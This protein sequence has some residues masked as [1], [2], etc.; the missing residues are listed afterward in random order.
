MNTSL[1]GGIIEISPDG[2]P[3]SPNLILAYRSGEKQGVI[4]NTQSF[5][6]ANHLMSASEISFDVHK[7]SGDTLCI[8]WD[9]IKDFKFVFVPHLG[10]ASFNPWYELSVTIDEN[11]DTIK[12]CQGVHAQESELGQ[13][14][15][16][17]VE[18]NTETDIAR[19]DYSPTV[20]YDPTNED[21]SLLH[22][23]LKDKASHYSIHHVDSSLA[24]QQRTFKWDGTSI[25]GAFNDIATELECLFIYGESAEDD[26]LI[27][28]T[29]S[30]YDLN[31]Y[32]LECGERGSFSNGVCTKCGSANIKYGYGDD[33]GIFLNRENFAENITY[34]SNKDQ[35]KNCFRLVA[36]DDLMTATVRNINPSGSQYIWYLSDEM[37]SQ[38]SALLRN[39]LSQY[40]D[41]YN[42]YE[43]STQIDIPQSVITA[44]NNLINKYKLYD[45]S[46][47]T[48]PYP[49]VGYA[50][51]TDLYYNALNFYSYL[52]TTLAPAS[53]IGTKTT[54]AKEIKKLTAAN[55]SPLGVSNADSISATSV[56]SQ[57]LSYAKIFVDTSLYRLSIAESEYANKVWTGRLTLTSYSDDQDTATT[58][59][60]TVQITDVETDYLRCQIERVMKKNDVDASGT[61]ALF[62][63]NDSQFISSLSFFS[64]DNLNILA[65]IVRGCLDVLIQQGIATP[66]SDLYSSMYLQYYNKS[67]YIQDELREREAEALILRGSRSNPYGVLDYIE[68]ARQSIADSLDLRSYLGETLW[69]EF[70]S[71]RRDD[72]YKNDNFISDGLSDTELI[73]QAQE[74]VKNAQREIIKSATLQHSISCNLNNFLLVKEQD[75]EASPI[76]IVT[77]DNVHLVTNDTMYLV[78]GDAIFS[79]LLVRFVVGN[80]L[81]IEIDGAVYKLRMTDYEINYD[82]LTSL[83]VEFSDVTYD[84]D[85]VSDIRSVLEKAQAVATSYNVTQRQANK[86]NTANDQIT[87]MVENGLD[88]TNKRIINSADNQTL[89]VDETGLLMRE[90]NDNDD[91]YNAEQ[92]KIIN[93]GFYY[94][95]DNW[96][97]VQTGLG[98]FIYFDPVSGTYQEDYGL[99]AHKIVGNIIIGNDLGIYNESGSLQVDTH[100]VTITSDADSV[101]PD[102]LTIR[103]KNSDGSYTRYVYI[104]NEGNIVING[105]HIQMTT[106]EDLPTYIENTIK[107]EA[108]ALVVQLTNEYIGISTNSDGG[109]GIFTNCNTEVMVFSGSI[110]ITSSADVR[111]TVT[112]T[113]GVVGTWD[114]TN[115]IYSVSNLASDFGEVV[116]D[117]EYNGLTASKKFRIAKIRDGADGGSVTITSTEIVYIPSDDGINPPNAYSLETSDSEIIIDQD[118]NEI[119]TNKWLP[120]IPVVVEGS[121]LWTR[122]TVNYSD[123]TSTV[124]Y[125]VARQG[126]DGTNGKDGLDGKDGRDGTSNY[127]HIKYSVYPNPT[128]EQMTE[129]PSNYIGVCVNNTIAD[130]VTSNSYVWSKFRGSDGEQGVPGNDCFVHFAYATSADGHTDFSKHEFTGAIYI[131]VYSDNSEDDS[132]DPDDYAWS[133]IKGD[134]GDD[135]ISITSVTEMYARNN[136]SASAPSDNDFSTTLVNVD[137]DH[138]Y[139]WNYEIIS[140]SEGNP[141][142]TAK[143]I[144][145]IFAKDGNNGRSITNVTNY[146]LATD[147]ASGVTR[148]GTQG[149]TD[150]IQFVTPTDK[151]LWNY[152]EVTYSSGNPSYSDACIIGVY[153]DSVSITSTTVEYIATTEKSSDPPQIYELIDNSGNNL[154]DQSGNILVSNKW[155]STMPDLEDGAYLWTRTT[156]EYS[157]GNSTVS[158]SNSKQGETGV[159]GRTYFVELDTSAVKIDS[160]NIITPST[161]TAS[162]YYRD[163]DGDRV[164][165]PCRFVITKTYKNNL[166][167]DVIRATSNAAAQQFTI[168]GESDM[169]AFYT[170]EIHKANEAPTSSNLL[171]IQTVPILVDSENLLIGAR[172]LLKLSNQIDGCQ[173]YGN[174]NIYSISPDQIDDKSVVRISL[175]SG[176]NT[177]KAIYYEVYTDNLLTMEYGTK[178]CVSMRAYSRQT[179]ALTF[180]LANSNGVMQTTD[181]QSVTLY[182]GWNTV[183]AVLTLEDAEFELVTE[184]RDN[185]LTSNNTILSTGNVGLLSNVLRI[186]D[187]MGSGDY[188][189]IN[190]IQLEKGNRPT[191]FYPSP[192]D[193]SDFTT[194]AVNGMSDQLRAMVS[195]VLSQVTSNKDRLDELTS[196]TGSIEEIRRSTVTTQQQ[197]DRVETNIETYILQVDTIAGQVVDIEKTTECFSMEEDGLR[198]TKKVSGQPDSEQLSMLLNEEELGFYQGQNKVAYFRNN[199]LYVNDASIVNKIEIGNFAFIPRSNGNLSFKYIGTNS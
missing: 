28:R 137:E 129:V 197:V 103:R 167:E 168:Y 82:D 31:D 83:N 196:D 57:L 96:R 89:L 93:H 92:V 10:T 69:A 56:N 91:D 190:Y 21:A 20:L 66:D 189:C 3:I 35:I 182:P 67:E 19:D 141:T 1:Y 175:T 121:Y 46:L 108:A 59:V 86:G 79:P 144:I 109:G 75:V 156:V 51:L 107:E 45:S 37:R 174:D 193:V 63:K 166:V 171:D 130:P 155:S 40:D 134:K 74:F 85:S 87:N 32:C 191:D 158:Y 186:T 13:L 151:Y 71:Y 78:K 49:I 160:N 24:N 128:D 131:G 6:Q 165:Y 22:R 11:D 143:R 64:I 65:N 81:H 72:T 112:A 94:T 135:G 29:I 73:A 188:Y 127:V 23:L 7:G 145:A 111:W 133:K 54:A 142:T 33:T 176:T 194:S 26:G 140:Y 106:T 39:K 172:N 9:E 102:L 38:M 184:D 146:Y 157:D 187:N 178:L 162:S 17:E 183:Y 198:I 88:L 150:S 8:L 126:I 25:H 44:Y 148:T 41:E 12:H 177:S 179:T 117:I 136:N 53:E 161:I 169:P 124:T 173:Y 195:D 199:L 34:S 192:E 52:K 114:S 122:T 18:I 80:W 149:W 14:T 77:V 119:A 147:Q 115:H 58:S 132:D 153:G 110:D 97:T 105:Q 42:D 84:M 62:E 70:C 48:C 120:D 100:G 125:T 90:R 185:L 5:I 61:V 95:N 181:A 163:G 47:V 104:D 43:S 164:S 50:A 139:L 101:N 113:T 154:V 15:I 2:Q 27:H 30:V 4:Q 16:N 55:L 36:G 180:C 138:K 98:K 76:P 159:P 170:V 68:S 123:G 118:G 60:L 152:E 99:I 116:F